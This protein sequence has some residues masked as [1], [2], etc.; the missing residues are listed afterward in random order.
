MKTNA[1]PGAYITVDR[2]GWTKGMQL[3][4]DWVEVD[5]G[6]YGYRLAGPKYNGSSQTLM[7]HHL[8]ARDLDELQRYID[9]ARKLI[10]APV[11]S[12]KPS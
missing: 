6:G 5:G 8:S 3:S 2:D 4:V 11:A 1:A 12:K 10:V 9:R 7:R